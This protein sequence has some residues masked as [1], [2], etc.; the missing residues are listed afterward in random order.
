MRENRTPGSV[1][2]AS[3]NRRPYRDGPQSVVELTLRPEPVVSLVLLRDFR[4]LLLLL[5]GSNDN[6]FGLNN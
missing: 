1:R 3:G 5:P 6:L 2:G 4:V